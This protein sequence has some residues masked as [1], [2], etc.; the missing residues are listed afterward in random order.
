MRVA[1]L[2][3]RRDEGLVQQN[4]EAKKGQGGWILQRISSER[5]QD[6]W[7]MR[8]TASGIERVLN[9]PRQR[10][11]WRRGNGV[12]VA[13]QRGQGPAVWGKMQTEKGGQQ[14]CRRTVRFSLSGPQEGGVMEQAPSGWDAEYI[15]NLEGKKE[16]KKKKRKEKVWPMTPPVKGAK[17][18]WERDGT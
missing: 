13:A 10:A 5:R 1:A 14:A 17:L 15:R 11:D 9:A 12:R 3:G 8:Q 16:E 18:G 2:S 4:G 6:T 7:R